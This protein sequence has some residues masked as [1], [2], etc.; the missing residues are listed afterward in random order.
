MARS[1]LW[2]YFKDK[3]ITQA[4]IA[5][6]TGFT[7]IYINGML[8]GRYPLSAGL[9]LAIL[10]AYPETARFLMPGFV[11][12]ITTPAMESTTA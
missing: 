1:Q 3:G 5:Q 7:L 11:V 2:Q 6:K 4:E 12:E 8:N 10:Q 9:T